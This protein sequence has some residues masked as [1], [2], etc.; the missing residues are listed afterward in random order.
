MSTRYSKMSASENASSARAESG[1]LV[2]LLSSAENRLD[3]ITPLTVTVSTLSRVEATTSTGATMDSRGSTIT[4]VSASSVL[5]EA[6]AVIGRLNT[7]CGSVRCRATV[8][9]QIGRAH[10]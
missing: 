3:C 8:S 2:T 6:G 4:G 10:V 9:E 7:G 5:S 1:V